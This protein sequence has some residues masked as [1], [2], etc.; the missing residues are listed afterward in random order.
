ML[1]NWA[2]G[3][4]TSIWELIND[5]SSSEGDNFGIIHGMM[6][7]PSDFTPRLVYAAVQNLDAL[8]SDTERDNSIAISSPDFAPIQ[9]DSGAPVLAYGFR[10]TKGKAIVGFWLA[11]HSWPH[12]V[13]VPNYV[14]LTLKNTGIEHPVLANVYTGEIKPLEWKAGTHDTLEKV[15]LLDSVQAIVDADYFDWPVLPEAP[16]SL[17]V[18]VASEFRPAHLGTARRRYDGHGGRAPHGRPRQLGASGEIARRR[19][20]VYRQPAGARP[21]PLLSG[22]GAQ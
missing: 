20:G 19:E 10:S 13:F 5:T 14:T 18:K 12:N 4:P 21:K 2:N 7:K 3:V 9:T 1:Y 17:E 22:P 8:F 16:S 6:F 11:A 15:P